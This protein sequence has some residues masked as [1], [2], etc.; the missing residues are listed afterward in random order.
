MS[1]EADPDG[2]QRRQTTAAIRHLHEI[3]DIE[4]VSAH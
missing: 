2:N 3:R 4:G 1:L